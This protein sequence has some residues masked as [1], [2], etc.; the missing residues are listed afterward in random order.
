MQEVTFEGT[1]VGPE[2]GK[3]STTK[4]IFQA[5]ASAEVNGYVSEIG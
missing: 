1:L 4:I 3:N 2:L 5:Q